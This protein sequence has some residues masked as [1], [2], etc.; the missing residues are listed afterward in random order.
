MRR[1]FSA[2]VV[3]V[4][5]FMTKPMW[6]GKMEQ[7]LHSKELEPITSR[8]DAIKNDPATAEALENAKVQ[9]KQLTLEIKDLMNADV[10]NQDTAKAEKP[11]L[12]K[13]ENQTFSVYNIELGDTKQNVEQTVGA[14]KRST[15]NEYGTHWNAYH[16]NYQNF[17]MIS[18][19]SGGKVNALYTDQD[20]L[21]SKTGIKI[22][23]PRDSVR[24][25]LGKP[26]SEM[27]KGLVFYKIESNG[28]YDVYH[29]DNSYV[30]IF[31]DKHEQN[32]VT[33][34]QIIDQKLEQDKN[35][36]YTTPSSSLEKGFEYQLFD[37]TNA[38]RVEHGLPYLTWDE[39]VQKT[40]LKHSEDMAENQ[41]FD[42]TNPKGQSPFDR[43]HEDD[44]YFLAAGE[45]LAYGQNS[46]IF[47]H[48]GLMNSLG[49]R[50]NILQKD[51]EY[52]GVG[53]AFG[54]QSQPYYTENFYSK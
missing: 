28:E 9:W 32:T 25:K 42:H 14:P 11:D 37:L 40:A 31:Y 26:M 50:K 46:S 24:E 6:E 53:V 4:V 5:L 52:L 45:N 13:P 38:A 10:Q 39:H 43:M 35:Q 51:F 7:L 49:H 19:D 15:E 34:I 21:S 27:R 36:Y 54:D 2:L 20:L 23:S 3:I 17:M 16:Q 29:M 33:A 47:A 8:F 48:E 12:A 1:F 41:Y 44:I 22:G 18:Y 30:T